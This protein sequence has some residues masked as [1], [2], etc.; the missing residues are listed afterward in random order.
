MKVSDIMT[1][2][3]RTVSPDTMVSEVASIMCLYR[4][5]GLPVVE[6]DQLVGMIA[7][8]DVLKILFPSLDEIMNNFNTIDY[9]E[10]INEYR[11]VIENTVAEVMTP[12]PISVNADMHALKA[13]AIIF[14]NKFR[15]IPVVNVENKLVGVLSVGDIH[16]AIYLEN[17][18]SG[19][20]FCRQPNLSNYSISEDSRQV[21]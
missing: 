2:N 15:R 12:N 16:R 9:S 7:E 13:S 6:H 1:T 10:Y 11:N 8:Q 18:Q 3:V 14:R 21:N 20:T 5:S 19:V 17:V 4:I